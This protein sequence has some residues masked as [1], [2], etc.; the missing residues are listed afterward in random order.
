MTQSTER[1]ASW[2][3]ILGIALVPWVACWFTLQRGYSATVRGIAFG[4]A[5]MMLLASFLQETP[6][7]VPQASATPTAQPPAP[8][9]VKPAAPKAPK[10]FSKQPLTPESVTRAVSGLE[11]SSY[12]VKLKTVRKVEIFEHAGAEEPNAKIVHVKYPQG[13]TWDTEDARKSA[14]ATSLAAFEVLFK[15]P[16]VYE[17][18]MWT[19]GEFIDAYGNKTTDTAMRVSMHREKATKVNWEGLRDL[20]LLDYKKLFNVAELSFLHPAMRR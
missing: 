9:P 8:V 3:L 18:V 20:V 17:V 2:W 10:A 7:P 11:N 19:E 1:K 4:W 15:H 12:R 6:V 5:A 13:S 14:A 16:D